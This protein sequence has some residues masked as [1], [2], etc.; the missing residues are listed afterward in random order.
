MTLDVAL[1]CL[2]LF[3]GHLFLLRRY[4]IPDLSSFGRRLLMVLYGINFA[5]ILLHFAA[6]PLSGFWAWYLDYRYGEFSPPASFAATQYMLLALTAVTVALWGMPRRW[7]HRLYW[8]GTALF[9]GYLSMD[10]Y[11]LVHED[12]EHWVLIYMAVAGLLALASAGMYWYGLRR[13]ELRVFVML[14][15]GLGIA[16]V[17]GVGLETLAAVS[18]FGYVPETCQRLPF[19][20][21]VLENLGVLTSLLG[22][23]LYAGRHIPAPGWAR[24]RRVVVGAGLASA[25]IFLSGSWI[26][27]TT[28]LRFF[29]QPVAIDY[30]EGQLSVLGYRMSQGMLQPGD[31]LTLHVYWRTTGGIDGPHGLSAH[32]VSRTA[33]E[34]AA[35]VNKLV[36]N[37]HYGQ[38]APGAVYRTSMI[39]ELPPDIPTPASYWLTLT[40]WADRRPNFIT[41]TIHQTDRYT[42]TPDMAALQTIPVVDAAADTPVDHA[43]RYDF[44]GDFSLT[45]YSARAEDGQLSLQFAWESRAPIDQQ[46]V[47][48]VHVFDASGDYIFGVDQPPFAGDF[49]TQD[50]PPGLRARADWQFDLPA[51]LP[52]G[53]YVLRTG[54]YEIDTQQR[55]PVTNDAGDPLPDHVIDLGAVRLGG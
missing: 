39:L 55:Q 29:A 6:R 45:G 14:L 7:W 4:V 3:G 46:L 13:R 35:S 10:E 40:T 26:V 43:V 2:L 38:A 21:E 53:D 54:L 24:A 41:Q 17:G 23:L 20:E 31:T 27:P 47:Q 34:S 19:I 51:D 9:L 25:L 18:C 48:F 33:G 16:S 49:P 11:F 36:H 28:E 42:L 50:W 5:L 8:S 52:A 30:M 37:P 22:V 44:Q 1:V 32:L 12:L 15:G